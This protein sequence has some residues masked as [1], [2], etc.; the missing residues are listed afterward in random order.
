MVTASPD[1][2]TAL[3]GLVGRLAARRRLVTGCVIALLVVAGVA[4]GIPAVFTS[5]HEH[6][7][8]VPSGRSSHAGSGTLPGV[9]SSVHVLVHVVGAVAHP[10]LVSVTSGSRVIDAVL[11]AGGLTAHADQCA[12]NL[13]RTLADGEQV[14]VPAVVPGAA[15]CSVASLPGAGSPSGRGSSATKAKVSLSR[16][17]EA[18]LEQLPG[19]GPALAQRIIDW[20]T[21]HG[22]FRQVSE[23]DN[24]SGIGPKLLAALTPLVT[25]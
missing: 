16:A 7:V 12:I 21:A 15:A 18:D 17:S 19:V 23:L 20:R 3:E 25:P 10:G 11:A 2:S 14:V 5:A 1:S 13:A 4:I 24:V 22:G 9:V 6:P 8:S